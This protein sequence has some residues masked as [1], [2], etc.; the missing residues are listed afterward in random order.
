MSF[1]RVAAM[2]M[3][4]LITTGSLQT[5]GIKPVVAVEAS[6]SADDITAA[7]SESAVKATADSGTCGSD[8]TYKFEDG[9]LTISGTGTIS[10]YAF[11]YSSDI[12]S[13]VIEEGITEIGDEAFYYCENLSSI[14]LPST[15]T[16]IGYDAFYNCTS[17][18]NVTI[19]ESV[20][21]I[22]SY[23]FTGCTS[24]ETITIKSAETAISNRTAL[25]NAIIIA[26]AGSLA[27]AFA[28]QNYKT[29]R[30]IETG[31][32]SL[33]GQLTET[34]TYS[35]DE[36]GV[37]TVSGTGEIPDYASV[38]DKS[39]CSA[40]VVE[41]GITSIGDEVF[42]SGGF[43][44]VSLPSTLE[45]IGEGA[46]LGCPNLTS[47]TIPDGVT[48]IGS[49]AFGSCNSLTSVTMPDSVTSLGD[50]A[51]AYC[52]GLTEVKLSAGLTSVGESTFSYCGN[53][54][55]ID[56]PEGVTE[57]G[58]EAFGYTSLT[59]VT[60]PESVATIGSNAFYG[61]SGLEKITIP[62]KKCV[63]KGNLT[64]LTTPI[65]GYMDSTAYEYCFEH[66]VKFIDIETGES[67]IRGKCGDDLTYEVSDDGVLTI[68]G[69][70]KMYDDPSFSGK[71]S[72]TSVVFDGEITSISEG[73]FYNCDG[74]EEI[75]IPETVTSIEADAFQSCDKLSKVTI[76][77][78]D[79]EIT[80]SSN[81]IPGSVS[82]EGYAGSTAQAYARKNGRT[83]IDIETGEATTGGDL[84]EKAS[85]EIKDGQ[86]IISGKGDLPDYSYDTSPF[87][88][89]NDIT[90]VVIE[91]GITGGGAYLFFSCDNIEEVT[92]PAGLVS[93]GAYEFRNTG[94]TS[95]ELPSTVTSIGDYAFYNCTSLET[96]KFS[97]KLTTIGNYVFN[98][99]SA[100]TEITLPTSL[101]EIGN[102]AFSYCYNMKL[103]GL[104]E[105]LETIGES[106]FYGCL[107]PD[108]LT[109]PESVKSI[110]DSAF[111]SYS[112]DNLKKVIITSKDVEILGT[113]S[114]FYGAEIF[115]YSGS[116]AQDYAK[117]YGMFFND[118]ETGE[119]YLMGSY[120]V[121]SYKIQDGVLTL[122]GS[123]PCEYTPSSTLPGSNEVEK[124]I[125]EDGVETIGSSAFSSFSKL[126]E[127][128]IPDSVT[129]IGS[130]AFAYCYDLDEV[131][132]PNAECDL[133]SGSDNC[134]VSNTTIIAGHTDSTAQA[135]AYKHGRKFHDIDKDTY[136]QQGKCGDD[137]T[138]TVADGVITITGT[139]EMYSDPSFSGNTD[140]TS[141]VIE[142]GVESIGDY[143]FSNCT[144][145]TSV[146]IP[147]TVTSIGESAFYYCTSLNNVKLPKGLKTIG[148]SS[149]ESCYALNSIN[150]PSTLET[151]G[152]E[153]FYSCSKLKEITFPD[154]LTSIGNS[155][156]NST[157]LTGVV[158]I[159][160][161]VKEIGS[162]AFSYSYSLTGVDIM[163]PECVLPSSGDILYSTSAY[164]GGYAGST[165]QEMALKNGRKFHNVETNEITIGGYCG[166]DM[167][168]TVV[169]STMTISGTGAMRPD[170]IYI[171]NDP[172]KEI[173]VEDGV[174]ELNANALSNFS[175]VTS[176]TLPAT[177]AIT[178]PGALSIMKLVTM[179][180]DEA[181]ENYVFENS[182]LFN[183]D[184]TQL[185][186]V[187]GIAKQVDI[188][189]TVTKICAGALSH[190]PNLTNVVL[191]ESVNEV[192]SNALNGVSGDCKI[193]FMDPKCVIS[194]S[195]STINNN[196][197]IVGHDQST[198]KEYAYN[199]GRRFMDI[200][201]GAVTQSGKCGEEAS[202]S[203][204]DD[205]L[206]ISG[207]GPM[208]DGST[209]NGK[210][211]IKKII[212][213]SGITSISARAFQDFD[214][215]TSVQIADTVE[216]IG[217][218]AFY[219]CDSLISI[220]IPDSVKEMG[221][222]VFYGCDA[223][224]S[225]Q[226]PEGLESI[227]DNTFSNCSKLGR[228]NIPDTVTS[229][230]ADA[231][232]YCYNLESIE[233]PESVTSIGEEAFYYCYNLKKIDLPKGITTISR[234]AFYDCY[235]I[236]SIE[237][238]EGV[239]SIEYSAF[240][241]CSGLTEI[242]IPAS[243]KSI[244]SSA[245]SSCSKIK[246]IT[247]ADPE[248]EIYSSSYTFP[249]Q[250]SI[251]GSAGS[252]AQTYAE[253][254]GRKFI[255]IE[256]G[257]V[258]QKG[259]CGDDLTYTIVDG[260]L[261]ISGTGAMSSPSPF[262]NHDQITA[263]I[264]E[265]GVTSIS[266]NGFYDCDS[267]KSVS[268]P[269]TLES[270]GSQAFAYCDVLRELVIPETKKTLTI[271][272]EA[273]YSYSD[274]NKVTFL[275]KDCVFNSDDIINSSTAIV[276]YLGSTADQYAEAHSRKFTDIETGKTIM[277]GSFGSGSK[278]I[279]ED[280][281]MT[282]SGT[283]ELTGNYNVD[284]S[285][286]TD[287][288]I[289][290]G[291]TG[292]GDSAF[293]SYSSLK[294]IKIPSTVENIKPTAFTDSVNLKDV[295]ISA[296]NKALVYEDGMILDAD[297]TKLLLVMPYVKK[298]QIPATVTTIGTF[299]FTGADLVEE[300]TLPK[301]VTDVEMGAFGGCSG[302][303]KLTVLNKKCNI[304]PSGV[305]VCQY[306][307][308]EYQDSEKV[309]T[310][311]RYS[312][313]IAGYVGSTTEE[314]AFNNGLKFLDLD[315]GEVIQKGQCGDD[316][317]YSIKNG[318]L[319]ITGS[320]EMY[321]DPSF[322]SNS[323]VTDIFIEEGVTAIGENA[324]K[325]FSKLRTVALPS[326]LKDIG[327]YAF[328]QCSNLNSVT[329]PS[330]LEN[331]GSYAFYN[332]K[333]LSSI[334]IPGTV[335]TIDDR[336][337]YYCNI[338]R[339][340]LE[341]GIETIGNYAFAENTINTIDIPAS[342][343]VIG[344]CAFGEPY[345][346]IGSGVVTI[347]N[348]ECDIIFS[349]NT[350]DTAYAIYSY[351][352][353]TAEKYAFE[354]G[355]KFGDIET[356]KVKQEG[357]CGNDL[358]FSIE[359]NVLNITG[360]GDMWD[361]PLFRG[362][363]S[364]VEVNIADG[365]TSIGK[366]AFDY[367]HMI[368]MNIP[369]SVKKIDASAFGYSN[370]LSSFTV[371]KNNEN[372]TVQ[373]GVLMSKDKTKVVCY[374]CN[375][376][377][378]EYKLDE[379]ITAIEPDAFLNNNLTMLMIL[380]KDCI[381]NGNID[382]DV[383]I[384][385]YK[386]S[387][388]ETFAYDNR[389]YFH[390]LDTGLTTMKGRCGVDL[391]YELSADGHLVISGTG[392]IDDN[393][394]SNNDNIKTVTI[395]EGVTSI[396][397][398]AFYDCDSIDEIELPSTVET[399]EYE[400]FYNSSLSS[401]KLN[402]GLKTIDGWA[403]EY[404]NLKKIDLPSTLTSLA[405]NVFYGVSLEE[406]NVAENS[407]TFASIDGVLYDKAL[408]TIIL[409]PKYKTDKILTLPETVKSIGSS[410]DLFSNNYNLTEIVITDPECEIYDSAETINTAR[411]AMV[412]PSTSSRTEFAHCPA[413]A[414][415][416]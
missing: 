20:V 56:I 192:E 220:I 233:I 322:R 360:T 411:D 82:V 148:T 386:G 93:I 218:S 347:L 300:V 45:T 235:G 251:V 203:V 190:C 385:G 46:F 288:V 23:A 42:Q 183:K 312:G 343:K 232:N 328:Y 21:E 187:S 295:E 122:S 400:A 95:I 387:T 76:L 264:I 285:L 249:S 265:E 113:N 401:I 141:A 289:E 96:V 208:S 371:D 92:L 99:C 395:E 350:F 150:L 257:E 162:S 315:T 353:S 201:T 47:V 64:D 224:Y 119:R 104:P 244:G 157:G 160:A 86:V 33:Y 133:A 414:R 355:R 204:E 311:T 205:A 416:M 143:A 384:A 261:T 106:A 40:L 49:S 287:V 2:V 412:M 174:T 65:E 19:P 30:D 128:Q 5:G 316:M 182:C 16:A 207:T 229:I 389:R 219:D 375:K 351:G 6:V 341:D 74:I 18:T 326:T 32:E 313:I 67:C 367:M 140:I 81:T 25:S 54:T 349:S 181:N 345:Y 293:S 281:V 55:S 394:F 307:D 62:N 215:V 327:D 378:T 291:I 50:Y 301:T 333:G 69:S 14:S 245:F 263:V 137:M 388:A 325:N 279:V 373:N 297:K 292:I 324:F 66:G 274:F 392:E 168:Y 223:L 109:I 280:G 79:C 330:G 163:D 156:F 336:A 87:Y 241:S 110:G 57:I 331:I 404:T 136:I 125:I 195:E 227:P 415:S 155:A 147:S 198:A 216:S 176:I 88:G 253:S 405:N 189:D 94:I 305:T 44:S 129:Y 310:S 117:K 43:E 352:G 9:V 266:S 271:E 196:A 225:V 370:Q 73:A 68:T 193:T 138:F 369:A 1:R 247:I 194:D 314:F 238:P 363:S 234:Y 70:G 38:M 51:F 398:Y 304:D 358:L 102:G 152:A 167:M 222:S 72:F 248:C 381:I 397:S 34:I 115:G 145:L 306:Y 364:I 31:E 85:F 340:T 231:F 175:N 374:P 170:S 296:D 37:M 83:F 191:P 132:I 180:I 171:S 161:S 169:G 61:C 284:T 126:T 112:S 236:T 359:G 303:T 100:L 15:L 262:E 243:V 299:A 212:I 185:L 246:E 22:G 103:A 309:Y 173:V 356:G 210:N 342:V 302:L 184:K 402:E 127:V 255:D 282:I 120:D 354:Y 78:K 376:G 259:K 256:T 130:N 107:F 24:L 116:T 41:D 211:N 213:E 368:T 151:I 134:I 334:S 272:Y 338:R 344:E 186:M 91:K 164:I 237:I 273:L 71:S 12:K 101:K 396:G 98:S 260:V 199:Y 278:Y 202:Y 178:D 365:V 172:V 131:L 413:Q 214:N 339:L 89:R 366:N 58:S 408:E 226:L 240:N 108:E 230:G 149:F 135:H 153:A 142:K 409:Y 391:T 52:Y 36:D 27:E 48:S 321:D 59:E 383:I 179:D 29:F 121:Y 346:S 239:T 17:L 123:G 77:N 11:E 97:K 90:S 332:C 177:A 4:I 380:N 28:R 35:V 26:P 80:D 357:K 270:I 39:S 329:L 84:G 361:E 3:A 348:P 197:T 277:R 399:I 217:D 53:L 60:L 228:V 390:D 406:I 308:Y 166:D 63:F 267:L 337:F 75:T 209:F 269:S 377:G 114:T 200:D 146:T 139:G 105:G 372:F 275:N 252:T 159:P 362:N 410:S 407:K 393:A 276:G 294:S 7:V 379:S 317:T 111:Y 318:I 290:E 221:I 165:A 188:P 144:S 118:L 154:S 158:A 13:V 10:S 242:S 258:T 403:F 382:S 268:L 124:V 320:G 335:K 254:F 283:G 8:A 319:S 206:I 298:L 323:E 286:V 250:A